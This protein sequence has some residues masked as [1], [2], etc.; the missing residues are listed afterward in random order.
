MEGTKGSLKF[1]AAYII[2][3]PVPQIRDGNLG[4]EAK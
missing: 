3:F 1:A 2:D 4:R